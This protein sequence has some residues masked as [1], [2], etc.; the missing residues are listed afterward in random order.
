MILLAFSP[1]ESNGSASECSESDVSIQ[2]VPRLSGL[3]MTRLDGSVYIPKSKQTCNFDQGSRKVTSLTTAGIFL[4]DDGN[5]FETSPSLSIIHRPVAP[6]VKVALVASSRTYSICVSTENALFSWGYSG[7]GC[8]GLGENIYQV[9]APAYCRSFESV[10]CIACSETHAVLSTVD[11][12][13]SWGEFSENTVIWEP[14]KFDKVKDVSLLAACRN[15]TL[16]TRTSECAV[17]HLRGKINSSVTLESQ[18]VKLVAEGSSAVALLVDGAVFSWGTTPYISQPANFKMIDLC[19]S[20]ENGFIYALAE[21]EAKLVDHVK[22]G[23]RPANLPSKSPKEAVTHQIEVARVLEASRRAREDAKLAEEEDKYLSQWWD[24]ALRGVEGVED[25]TVEMRRIWSQHGLSK[26]GKM[27]LWPIALGN[28]FSISK[29]IYERYK[30]ANHQEY[31]LVNLD[32]P[33]TFPDLEILEAESPFTLECSLLLKAY[34]TFAPHVGYV[35]GMSFVAVTLLMHMPSYNAFVCF[36]ALMEYVVLK[37]LYRVKPDEMTVVFSLLDDYI[38]L[39]SPALLKHMQEVGFR[40]D[41]FLLEWFLT[42]FTK[43]LTLDAASAVW[44]IVILDGQTGV[45]QVACGIL[46]SLEKQIIGQDFDGCMAVIQ[47]GPKSLSKREL[48][49]K[50]RVI[51]HPEHAVEFLSNLK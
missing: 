51:K 46:V 15:Q 6:S 23:F 34:Q 21:E 4:V 3:V 20:P 36:C 29:E 32:M 28:E 7:N 39:N 35:Q 37:M 49:A 25:V 44:D 17:V 13:F 26:P 40:R 1:E 9:S 10:S 27:I 24:T 2:C 14:A 41:I 45:F 50:I 22:R 18:V 38:E 47:R 31:S 33:R 19:I 42:L 11:G 48:L 43:C 12:L 16:W 30:E 5:I 8:L